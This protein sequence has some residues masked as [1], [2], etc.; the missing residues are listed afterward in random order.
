MSGNK[1]KRSDDEG[2][3]KYENLQ[4][5]K[6][7]RSDGR[8]ATI[9]PDGEF[10]ATKSEGDSNN[11]DGV[12]QA[13]ITNLASEG[14][15]FQHRRHD[16]KRSR[17]KDP[18]AALEGNEANTSIQVEGKIDNGLAIPDDK[19]PN[20]APGES[21]VQAAKSRRRRKRKSRNED[22]NSVLEANEAS[23]SIQAEV[24]MGDGVS[25]P[26]GEVAKVT[27]EEQEIKRQRRKEKRRKVREERE[28]A[29][30]IQET[31][32]AD[33]EHKH[34]QDAVSNG[35]ARVLDQ[36]ENLQ[37]SDNIKD[38][39]AK[40]STDANAAKAQNK[41]EA[42]KEDNGKMDKM[43]TAETAPSGAGKAQKKPEKLARSSQK[44]Q[45]NGLIKSKPNRHSR[46]KSSSR[47]ESRGE[48]APTWRVS[49][50]T[51][52]CM[53]RIDPLFSPSEE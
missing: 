35:A 50:S 49:E 25:I 40:A 1:R 23:T 8:K 45:I 36:M 18:S 13:D 26:D 6:R 27:S 52:G 38:G 33:E 48:T 14:Q 34:D 46:R 31:T 30:M 32:K 9:D 3:S 44:E 51:G 7:R 29:K 42:P 19:V 24:K 43:T 4:K 10:S 39:A 47:N 41:K 53:L 21:E 5:Q 22:P 37:S 16:K 28:A 17:K 15:T 2:Q 11:N 12:P 20:V